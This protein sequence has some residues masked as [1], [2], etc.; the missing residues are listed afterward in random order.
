MNYFSHNTHHYLEFF[1]TIRQ[2]ISDDTL[3]LL[4]SFI[5]DQQTKYEL[6]KLEKEQ[7][8]KQ[9][10]ESGDLSSISTESNYRPF[11][12]LKDSEN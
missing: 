10:E 11:K 7:V 2:C 8:L 12:K 6:I 4:I 9:K 5:S 3:P 1:K